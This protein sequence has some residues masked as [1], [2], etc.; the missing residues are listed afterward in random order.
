MQPV[1]NIVIPYHLCAYAL[2]HLYVCTCSPRLVVPPLCSATMTPRCAQCK[3]RGSTRQVSILEETQR[4]AVLQQWAFLSSTSAICDLC[5]RT[6]PPPPPRKFFMSVQAA[7]PPKN[8]G[9]RLGAISNVDPNAG[10]CVDLGKQ[11]PTLSP[12][13]GP[14]Q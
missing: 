3:S 7:T 12:S 8:Q 13:C 1:A 14:L 9:Q 2:V 6:A 5:I 4:D 11:N 10:N